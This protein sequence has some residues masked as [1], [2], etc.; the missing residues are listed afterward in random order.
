MRESKKLETAFMIVRLCDCAT[1][2]S[3]LESLKEI[4][5][6]IDSHQ[7]LVEAC[8]D[9]LD[10]AGMG[11]FLDNPD[12]DDHNVFG[13]RKDDLLAIRAALKLAEVSR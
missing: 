5:T 7:V 9:S 13:I 8:E 12:I 11:D 4:K 10:Y 1:E 3:K 6:F 2:E